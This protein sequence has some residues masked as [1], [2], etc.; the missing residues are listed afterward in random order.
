MLEEKLVKESIVSRVK[1]SKF[2]ENLIFISLKLAIALLE[3]VFNSPAAITLKS[4][5]NEEM[6]NFIFSS[7]F[8]PKRYGTI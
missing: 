5:V 1:L 6:S 4:D 3:F 8:Y 2:F 7:V